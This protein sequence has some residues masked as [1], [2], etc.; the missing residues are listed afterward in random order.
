MRIFLDTNVLVSAFATRGLCEDV[1]REVLTF[2]QLLT[3][4]AVIA[5]F[6]RVLLVKLGA[7]NKLVD[8]MLSFLHTNAEVLS[9]SLNLDLAINDA[10]DVQIV[11]DAA[12][13]ASDVLVTGDKELLGLGEV[14]EMKILSPRQFWEIVRGK[15]SEGL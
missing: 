10:S 4:R 15:L 11:S 13:G 2:H 1:F 3:S 12:S 9:G 8:E 5:E 7:P 6:Q 14:G